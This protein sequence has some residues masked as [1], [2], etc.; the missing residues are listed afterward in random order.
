V[1]TVDRALWA[2]RLVADYSPAAW[3]IVCVRAVAEAVRDEGAGPVHT[4]AHYL[5]AAWA[6]GV[7]A[8]SRWPEA[9]VIGSPTSDRALAELALQLPADARLW[10]GGTDQLDAVL[11]AEILLLADR[12][13]EGYQRAGIA[14]FVAA[15][16]ARTQRVLARTYSDRDPAFERFRARILGGQG[17]EQ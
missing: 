17:N 6:P 14:A 4:P 11:A 16:R 15:E 5:A 12:N 1:L 7:D 2:R 3:R 9:V 10:L 13:L 8:P